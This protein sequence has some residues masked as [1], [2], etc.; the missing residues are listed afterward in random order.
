MIS[1]GSS[2][3]PLR[4]SKKSWLLWM[5]CGDF[6]T[7]GFRILDNSFNVVYVTAPMLVAAQVYMVSILKTIAPTTITTATI[8]PTALKGKKKK[9]F[10]SG[11]YQVPPLQRLNLKYWHMVQ[12]LQWS[13]HVHQLGN[14]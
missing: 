1:S 6:P 2:W 14:T 13:P 12:T 10:G 7:R 9:T 3:M 11:T 5:W 4:C 8:A